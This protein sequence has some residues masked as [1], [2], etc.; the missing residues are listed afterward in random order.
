MYVCLERAS[1][2]LRNRNCL[3][4]FLESNSRWFKDDD[5]Q[6]EPPLIKELLFFPFLQEKTL[7]LVERNKKQ[8]VETE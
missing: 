4:N 5:S 7:N 1:Q 2:H 3:L 6:Y 8:Y